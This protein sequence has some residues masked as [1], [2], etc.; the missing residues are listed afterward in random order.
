[1]F[2]ADK[3]RNP[4]LGVCNIFPTPSKNLCS[5]F[6][7]VVKS[8]EFLKVAICGWDIESADRKAKNFVVA[9]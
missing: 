2:L 4:Q 8:D 6:F 1:M 9:L 7:A 5:I 3:K